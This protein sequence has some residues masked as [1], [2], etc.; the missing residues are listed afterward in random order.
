MGHSRSSL[1]V[2]REIVVEV[3]RSILKEKARRRRL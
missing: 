2:G 3:H 1:N